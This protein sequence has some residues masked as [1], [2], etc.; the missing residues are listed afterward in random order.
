MTLFRVCIS[1]LYC[2]SSAFFVL[3]LHSVGALAQTADDGAAQQ[4]MP[5]VV[6]GEGGDALSSLTQWPGAAGLITESD[7]EDSAVLS[8]GDALSRQPGIY[9]QA[10]AGQQALKLS[11]R[12]SGLASPL[13]M[14]GITL[15]RDGL[16]L[17]MADGTVDPSY[18]DPFNAQYIETY[19]GANAVAYGAASLGGAINLISPTGYS[20]PGPQLRLQGGSYGSLTSQAR[21]GQVLGNGLDVFASISRY[22]TNGS[23][24][25]ARQDATRF[26]GNLGF[27]P[28]SRSEGRFHVDVANMNQEVVTPLTLAQLQDGTD[29]QYPRWPQQRIHTAPRTWLAY[30]HALAYGR[31]D[32]VAFGT[33]YAETQFELLGT[34]VPIYYKTRDYGVSLRGEVY[35]RSNQHVNQ[36]VWGASLIQGRSKSDTYGPFMLPGGRVLDRSLEQYEAIETHA[37]TVQ[38]YVENAYFLTPKISLVAAIQGVLAERYRK[39]D[40]LRNPIGL[41]YFR[42]IDHRAHYRGISPKLGI[43]WRVAR[44]IQIFSNISRSYEPPTLLEFYNSRGTTAAQKG[45][46]FEI[47]TRGRS[48]SLA[49]DAALFHSRIK[50]ELLS[51]PKTNPLRNTEY[52]G[53]NIP[54]TTHSGLELK[55]DGSLKPRGM[56]GQVDWGLTYAWSRFRFDGDKTFGSK[57]LPTVPAHFGRLEITR[58]YP[59]GLYIGPRLEFASSAYADQANTLQAPGYG[60]I[61]LALGYA[62]ASKHY[63]I[64]IDARNLTD[65]RYAA[66]T[67]Y[68]VAAKPGDAV[69]NPGLRRSIFI[70]GEFSW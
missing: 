20:H 21:A 58:R 13:G 31:D 45:V 3:I 51:I 55:L 19:R 36:L 66:S 67:E 34:A 69:F 44:D 61:N 53:G 15:L 22:Q 16:P 48:H 33:H 18:V 28:D 17:S 59:S 5:I 27:E 23:A 43:S 35:R 47:G 52:E 11:I 63:R 41:D 70:G 56:K 7:Y 8:L 57:R 50:D 40:A 68:V 62:P 14:R 65:R 46:T 24:D 30:Q 6:S 4:L 10:S 29:S 12:G 39:I 49:W 32:H 25:H 9:A 1:R 54:R 37:Q 26:Y 38:A 64:F 2:V 42:D 60:I